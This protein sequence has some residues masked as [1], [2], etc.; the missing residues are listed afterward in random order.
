MLDLLLIAGALAG[1]L[2]VGNLLVKH[3][4][5]VPLFCH[6]G[7]HRWDKQLVGR[8]RDAQYVVKCKGCELLRDEA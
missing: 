2:V 7:L 1:A 6:L 4:T 3:L 5:G 8:G